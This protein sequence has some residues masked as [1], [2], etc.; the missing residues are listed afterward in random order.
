MEDAQYKSSEVLL[1]PDDMLLLY[2]DGLIE[3]QSPKSDLY[4]QQLLQKAVHR[5]MHA[6]APQLLDD[7]LKEVREFSGDAP[8][9]DDVCIVGMELTAPPAEKA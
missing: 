4:T 9:T 6:T 1:S 2:T 5:L 8:F 7:L 3:V